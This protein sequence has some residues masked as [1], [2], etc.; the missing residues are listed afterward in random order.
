MLV[1]I[2][3][4]M[5]ASIELSQCQSNLALNPSQWGFDIAATASGHPI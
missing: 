1:K 3:P 4:N 2:L 5:T